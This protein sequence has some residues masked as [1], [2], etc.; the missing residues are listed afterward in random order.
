MSTSKIEW[1]R[2]DVGHQGSTWNPITGCTHSGSPGCDNCYAKRMAQRL[3]GRYGY[4]EDDPFRVTFHP[5]KLGQPLKWKKSRKIFVVSMGDLFHEDVKFEWTAAI[6]GIMAFCQNHTF[7][8]LTKRPERM[9]EFFTRFHDG[10]Y[11]RN[12]QWWKNEACQHLPENE[13]VG[14]C[15]RSEPT[16]LPLPNVIGMVT[17][18]N[19]KHADIR[20]PLLLQSPFIIRGISVEPM[21][22]P[23]DLG[24]YL[25]QL[26]YNPGCKTPMIETF[27]VLGWV[28]CGGE[29][30]AGARPMHPDWVRSLK[31]QCISAGVPFFFKQWGAW[32]GEEGWYL[33]DKF[34]ANHRSMIVD[35]DSN[36]SVGVSM[37][38][39]GKKK[40]GR[41]LD[42]KEWNQFPDIENEHQSR[43]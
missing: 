4:P 43:I 19:Q 18:E 6:F 7:I 13:S 33:Q 9:L 29:S 14:I 2:D 5:D 32:T 40:T 39:I 21:I 12:L 38:R 1:L 3:K 8:V 36:D 15:K 10:D 34:G 41:L 35:R 27:M 28:I 31:D 17:T 16:N 24:K 22:G 37:G 11:A 23:V 42:G 30:G 25:P 20:I 26:V